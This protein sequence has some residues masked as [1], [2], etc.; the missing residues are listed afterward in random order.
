MRLRLLLLVCAGGFLPLTS[1]AAPLPK[2]VADAAGPQVVLHVQSAEELIKRVKTTLQNFLPAETYKEAETG[3]DRQFD[4]KQIPFLDVKKPAGFYASFDPAILRGEL[5]GTT[6]VA[7]VPVTSEKETI[8]FLGKVGAPIKAEKEGLYVIEM[9]APSPKGFIRFSEG[10][11]YIGLGSSASVDPK[12]LLSAKDLFSDKET[13]AGL[14]KIRLDRIPE[15]LKLVAQA[16]LGFAAPLIGQYLG[17]ESPMLKQSLRETFNLLARWTKTLSADGKELA[18]RADLNSKTAALDLELSID[19]KLKSNYAESLREYK[20][21]EN[22]FASLVGKDSCAHVFMKA[23]LFAPELRKLFSRLADDTGARQAE[24]MRGKAPPE[25][26][27]FS[28]IFFK[29]LS[30]T[31]TEGNMDLAATLN[32]PDKEGIYQGIAAIQCQDP[33]ALEKP[34][35]A[36]FK[37][38]PMEVQQVMKFNAD[39]IGEVVVHHADFTDLFPESVKKVFGKTPKISFCVTEEGIFAAFGSDNLPALKTALAAKKGLAPILE[40]Q[41]SPKKFESMVK[42]LGGETGRMELMLMNKETLPILRLDTEGGEKL[43]VKFTIGAILPGLSW[44]LRGV[45]SSK[46]FQPVPLP[47]KKTKE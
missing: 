7:L 27:D 13:A 25:V 38:A 36:T 5:S 1:M 33:K 44:S 37:I 35:I 32:G 41:V 34:F 4:L 23:P 6:I 28:E 40:M 20:A 30:K 43:K 17:S 11:A 19:G 3:F 47:P 21:P 14:L 29:T 39:K 31:A 46:N 15:D 45:S 26:L 18:I 42:N 16:G 22:R 2:D 24:A 10:Y 9:P 12:G 8:D